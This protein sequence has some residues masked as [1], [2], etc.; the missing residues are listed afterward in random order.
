MI[1]SVSYS[2]VTVDVCRY[3]DIIILL[4]FTVTVNLVLIFADVSTVCFSAA[5][6]AVTVV[7]VIAL[8]TVTALNR[9]VQ[10]MQCLSTVHT[11]QQRQQ[12]CTYS[13]LS[14]LHKVSDTM[15]I[16]M[17]LLSTVCIEPYSAVQR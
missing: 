16:D 3:L 8:L 5:A 9:R 10:T 11:I 4:K 13:Q 14:V 2:S 17:L 1:C 6:A 15:L 12:V 7:A